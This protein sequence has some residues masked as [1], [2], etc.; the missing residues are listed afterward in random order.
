MQKPT[1]PFKEVVA[2]ENKLYTGGHTEASWAEF[3]R[4]MNLAD[5]FGIPFGKEALDRSSKMTGSINGEHRKDLVQ[6]LQG[7]KAPRL[8]LVGQE[9]PPEAAGRHGM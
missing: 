3:Q 8:A 6:A 7:A 2:D 9:A 5:F 1:T 4:C